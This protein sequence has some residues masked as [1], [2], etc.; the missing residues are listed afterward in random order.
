MDQE[1]KGL[2]E[3]LNTAAKAA[4]EIHIRDR[5]EVIDIQNR[6]QGLQRALRA[7]QASTRRSGTRYRELTR[8]TWELAKAHGVERIVYNQHERVSRA[9][10]ADE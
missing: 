10:T 7:A 9:Y 5:T 4:E 6:I 1:T 8:K 2:I 3:A